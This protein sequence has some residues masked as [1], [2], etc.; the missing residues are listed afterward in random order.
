MSIEFSKQNIPETVLK[1]TDSDLYLGLLQKSSFYSKLTQQNLTI[2]LRLPQPARLID[3]LINGELHKIATPITFTPFA[4]AQHCSAHCTF[5]SETLI[6]K[7]SR[8]LSA[9]LRPSSTYFLGLKQAL[10]EL[11][12]LPM[13]LSLS[14]LEATD[15]FSWFSQTLDCF[16]EYETNYR[17]LEEKILYSNGAGFAKEEKIPLFAKTKLFHFTRIEL[18]RHHFEQKKNNIIMRFSQRQPI[19]VQNVFEHVVSELQQNTPIRLVCIL[20]KSGIC[21][22]EGILDYLTWAKKLGISDVVFRELSRI[23]DEYQENRTFQTIQQERVSL[24]SILEKIWENTKEFVPVFV[25]AGYYFWNI[26]FLWN[27]LNV[28]FETSDYQEMKWCHSSNVIYKLIY[29]ANGNLCGDWDPEKKIL[30]GSL[31]TKN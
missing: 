22:L 29:H 6:H 14:G 5:C 7:N 9:S 16:Q 10:Q 25:T 19:R 11:K 20:Q 15:H 18:S 13:S 30:L 12:S 26:C 27:N 3:Y 8:L 31:P 24:E 4:S 1:A 28:T 2:R 21:T 23:G 17:P